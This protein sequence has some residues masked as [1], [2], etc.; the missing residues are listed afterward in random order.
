MFELLA[1]TSI[2]RRGRIVTRHGTIETPVFFPVGTTG[3]MRGLTF[4]QLDELGAQVLLCNTYHLHLLP[5]DEVV[6]EA[7]GLHD[8][9]GWHK[10]ILTDSGGYQ[11][12]SMRHNDMKME[13][14]GVRFKSHLNGSPL[15]IGPEEAMKI[16]HN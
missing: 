16:Q 13:E 14:N 3:A 2:G 5:G 11:V 4:E 15:F 1:H 12:F 6:A 9:I 7:G 10:P 8:F